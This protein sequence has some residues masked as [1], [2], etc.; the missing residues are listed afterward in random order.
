MTW[1]RTHVAWRFLSPG[2]AQRSLRRP[3]ERELA[4]QRSDAA[5]EKAAKAQNRRRARLVAEGRCPRCGEPYSHPVHANCD[6]CRANARKRYY[7]ATK[8]NVLRRRAKR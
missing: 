8:G 4:R 2:A 7:K 6:E 5:K 1:W 3:Y